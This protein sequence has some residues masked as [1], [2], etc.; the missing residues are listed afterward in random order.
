MKNILM[1]LL[2]VLIWTSPVL[3]FLYEIPILSKEE[4][5]KL[6]DEELLDSY[7]EVKIEEKTSREFHEGAGYNSAK[8]YNK[9][10]AL[11]RFLYYLRKEIQRRDLSM[12]PVED[13]IQ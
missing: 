4:I 11:L 3:A 1:I 6:S 7:L 9:R 5:V 10:K 2:A 8:E 13:W 12:D